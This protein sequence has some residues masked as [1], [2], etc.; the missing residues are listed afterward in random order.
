M[1]RLCVKNCFMPAASKKKG[2]TLVEILIV[3]VI[4]GI[5]ASVIIPKFSNAN[6]QAR[7]NMLLENLRILRTQIATYRAQH[8]D[9]SPGYDAAT[10]NPGEQTFLDQM[11]T[12]TD[13]KGNTSDEGSAVFQYCPYLSRMPENPLNNLSSIMVIADDVALPVAPDNSTGW[14]YKP[15]EMV[16]RANSPGSGI[17]LRDYYKY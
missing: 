11:T 9:V 13:E 12:F 16:I 5:L 8:W 3:V 2:F 10:G 7:E 6:M 17:N 1:A 15:S 14:I 4:L